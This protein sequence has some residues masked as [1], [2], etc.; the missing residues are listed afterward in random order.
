MHAHAVANRLAC[1][2]VRQFHCVTSTYLATMATLSSYCLARVGSRSATSAIRCMSAS[3]AAPPRPKN[4]PPRRP[5]NSRPTPIA[6]NPGLPQ[7]AKKMQPRDG[8]PVFREVWRKF[9]LLVHPDLFT[10]FPE[11][12]AKNAESLQ[13]LQ[14]ILNEAKSTEREKEA[15]MRARTEEMEF[16]IRASKI[17]GA[18]A[19][20]QQNGASAAAESFVRVPLVVRIP[21]P[22]C[23]HVLSD[24]LSQL[25]GRCR[26]PTRWHW[27]D[28]YFRSTYTLA[29]K[30][31]DDGYH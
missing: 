21:G 19:A 28:D 2:R 31:Q 22:N 7:T 11:L 27:G 3:T 12:Q 4:A 14:G 5:A 24:A 10:R 20:N 6:T 29:P 30:P 23:Q 16:Y 17:L 26:L 13:K 9:Q 18:A 15:A 25:F 1:W 8:D